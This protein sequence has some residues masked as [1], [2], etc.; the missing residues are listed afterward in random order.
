MSPAMAGWF[1]TT[2]ATW[3]ALVL[4]LLYSICPLLL[5]LDSLKPIFFLVLKCI[6]W[7]VDG[8]Y[9]IYLCNTES[10]F[11]HSMDACLAPTM[12]QALC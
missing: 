7:F 12:C 1:F 2:S 6:L 4:I 8:F 3:E 10:D 11:I 9:V 5:C